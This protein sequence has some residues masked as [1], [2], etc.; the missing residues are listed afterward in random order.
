MRKVKKEGIKIFIVA[1]A[2][3]LMLV[4]CIVAASPD[5]SLRFIDP[6]PALDSS[7]TILNPQSYPFIGE[8]GT[9]MFNT[10]G[11]AN[12]TITPVNNTYFGVDIQFLELR[13]GDSVLTTELTDGVVF[14]EDYECNETCYETSKVLTSGKH[15][16]E[17][18][19]GDEVEYAKNQ[20]AYYYIDDDFETDNFD[21][22]WDY[23]TE[24]GQAWNK[25]SSRNSSGD[26][27]AYNVEEGGFSG[28][29]GSQSGGSGF[30]KQECYYGSWTKIRDITLG[31]EY[32]FTLTAEDPG[33]GEINITKAEHLDENH[34]FI[35]DI[36][37]E[38]KAIDGN[39]SEPIY[40]NEYVR[41]TFEANMTNG[42]VI[43]LYV[44][45]NQSLDT[46]I[47]IYEKDE[48]IVVASTLITTTEMYD[49]MLS[50]MTGYNTIFDIKVVNEQKNSSAFLEFDYIHDADRALTD[51]SLTASDRS[52]KEGDSITITGVYAVSGG[53]KTGNWIIGLTDTNNAIDINGACAPGEVFE[54]T[55]IDI[56]GCTDCTDNGDGTVTVPDTSVGALTIVWTLHSC[57]DSSSY[58][59]VNLLTYKVGGTSTGTATFDAYTG[60]IT[61]CQWISYN[62]MERIPACQDDDFSDDEHYVYMNGTGFK[63]NHGY[64]VGYYDIDKYKPDSEAVTSDADG[65][66]HSKYYFPYDKTVAWGTPWHAVAYDN[67]VAPP[68]PTYTADD[69]NAA[70]DD[71]FSVAESAIP[72]FS[73]VI[74]AIAV[75]MLCAVSYLVMRRKA[76]KG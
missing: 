31:E 38:V 55:S 9:V 24:D 33:F 50:K 37:D 17:F 53:S 1:L 3:F 18:R 67:T 11:Q 42:N 13:C 28:G 27:S 47:E 30:A 71:S 49:L 64:N 69:P 34:T 20:Q 45:N 51:T 76:E 7:I 25:S 43:N 10:T 4:F 41:A 14:I 2:S 57:S 22:E 72:E 35:S 48:N 19:F 36:Y 32:S 60:D 6:T 39:W 73:T 26:Y 54:A 66:L 40:A 52:I 12:L 74:A 23:I 65:T 8:N 75:C 16:L 59:P 70:A 21:T 68:P 62:C 63:A 15:T 29:R 61:I 44:R 46:Y 5:S 56:S 58:S